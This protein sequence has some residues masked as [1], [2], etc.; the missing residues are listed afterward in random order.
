MIR[1]RDGCKELG[2][3]TFVHCLRGG[4][5]GVGWGHEYMCVYVCVLILKWRHSSLQGMHPVYFVPFSIFPMLCWLPL[6]WQ[7]SKKNSFQY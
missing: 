4:G 7:L 1:V 2:M 5:W 6:D 3:R